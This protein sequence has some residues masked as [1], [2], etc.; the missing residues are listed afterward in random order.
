MLLTCIKDIIILFLFFNEV[1]LPTDVILT[2]CEQFT[3]L[4]LCVCL[5]FGVRCNA[6]LPGFIETSMTEAV[7]EKIIEKV[8]D[9]WISLTFSL[10]KV[11]ILKIQQTVHKLK[12]WNYILN[13]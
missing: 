9:H 12:S 13:K 7:P 3:L 8:C 10:P 11:V 6:V 5:R 4:L 2:N 1:L